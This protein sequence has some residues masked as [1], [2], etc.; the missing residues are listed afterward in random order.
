MVIRHKLVVA[1]AAMWLRKR[2]PPRLKRYCSPFRETLWRVMTHDLS[3]LG[4]SCIVGYSQKWYSDNLTKTWSGRALYALGIAPPAPAPPNDSAS[5][6]SYEE[7]RSRRERRWNEAFLRH[8]KLEDHH[9]E[10]HTPDVEMR[11]SACFE[12]VCD[13]IAAEVSYSQSQ[14]HLASPSPSYPPSCTSSSTPEYP[15]VTYPRYCGG[16]PRPDWPWVKKNLREV[17]KKIHPNSGALLVELLLQGGYRPSLGLSDPELYQI[18]ISGT[19]ANLLE[20]FPEIS[21]VE[22]DFTQHYISH[23]ECIVKQL[24]VA[25]NLAGMWSDIILPLARSSVANITLQVSDK[26]FIGHYVKVK[27]VPGGSPLESTVKFGI[28]FTKNVAHKSMEHKLLNPRVLLIGFPLGIYSDP[29]LASFDEMIYNERDILY[30]TIELIAQYKPNIVVTSSVVNRTAIDFFLERDIVVV[31]NVKRHLMKKLARLLG[32]QIAIIPPIVHAQR[33]DDMPEEIPDTLPF[34]T[35]SLPGNSTVNTIQLPQPGVCT[36]QYVIHFCDTQ[37]C[38]K[39]TL[40]MFEGS[41][42]MCATII[43]RGGTEETLQKVKEIVKFSVY[44]LYTNKLEKALHLEQFTKPIFYTEVGLLASSSPA[45]TIP[46]LLETVH[47]ISFCYSSQYS[48]LGLPP[49]LFSFHVLE[50]SQSTD[51]IPEKQNVF[52]PT[53]EFQCGHPIFSYHSFLVSY[54]LGSRVSGLQCRS[55]E[56]YKFDFYS[57]CDMSLGIFLLGTFIHANAI[58]PNC[59]LHMAQHEQSFLHDT[60][61]VNVVVNDCSTSMNAHLLGQKQHVIYSWNHCKICK[62]SSPVV[63]LSLD[64]FNFSFGQFLRNLFYCRSFHRCGHHHLQNCVEYFMFEKQIIELDYIT[65]AVNSIEKRSTDTL[66]SSYSCCGQEFLARQY[67]KLEEELEHVLITGYELINRSKQRLSHSEESKKIELDPDSEANEKFHELSQALQQFLLDFETEISVLKHAIQED[68]LRPAFEVAHYTILSK[69]YYELH[70]SWL[71]KL[72]FMEAEIDTFSTNFWRSLPVIRAIIPTTRDFSDPLPDEV[73]QENSRQLEPS[74]EEKNAHS[75][76]AEPQREPVITLC[77]LHEVKGEI[78]LNSPAGNK[79]TIGLPVIYEDEPSSILAYTLGCREFSESLLSQRYE[80]GD[81]SERQW[82]ESDDV[83]TEWLKCDF[84]SIND[85]TRHS[86]LAQLISYE[87]SHVMIKRHHSEPPFRADITCH[88]IYA[89]QFQAL[90]YLLWGESPASKESHFLKSLSR[91]TRWNA[92][93]GK[94]ALFYKTFDDRIVVKQIT[95]VEMHAF[96]ELAPLYFR[97]LAKVLTENVFIQVP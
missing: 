20:G 7:I 76:E 1:V 6:A 78:H 41:S 90:R 84:A 55:W 82:E 97:Y 57:K 89:K 60:G 47:K 81:F 30:K 37:S 71:S 91:C 36:R 51:L 39:K 44:L 16:W 17:L 58:C 34:P 63:P 29:E 23:V 31:P 88:A 43:L 92:Q 68:A 18:L 9:H 96:I 77:E 26:K 33:P 40:M 56:I 79:E 73:S 46:A 93:G 4:P 64:T 85:E 74:Q 66:V 13:W 83:G 49:I 61:R 50:S 14:T 42:S 80:L 75:T 38:T 11:P 12:L 3:K 87:N 67:S 5:L 45:V 28:G 35:P 52:S 24:L 69:C 65:L 8:A 86:L 53:S 10:H 94:K 62:I 32:C 25:F 21:I 59:G 48:P 22:Q 95:S 2:L 19:G 27:K 70:K 15:T 72:H 54:S